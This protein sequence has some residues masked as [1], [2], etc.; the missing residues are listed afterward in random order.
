MGEDEG[1]YAPVD[2]VKWR[3]ICCPVRTSSTL[4]AQLLSI[5]LE[6]II[7]RDV[8]VIAEFFRG[9]KVLS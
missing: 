4:L 8:C 6:C 1:D 7:L 5:H 2:M 9:R 3:F